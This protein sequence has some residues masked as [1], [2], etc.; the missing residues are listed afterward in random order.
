MSMP[1]DELC[2]PNGREDLLT[3]GH[4]FAAMTSFLEAFWERDGRPDDSMPK[5]LG[6]INQWAN[7][8]QADSAMWGDWLEA[9]KRTQPQ[10]TRR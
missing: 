8:G 10:D 9:I 4:A 5:L 7:S 6:W 3:T 1:R 2:F